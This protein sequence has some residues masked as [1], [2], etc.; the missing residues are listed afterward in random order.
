MSNML[1]MAFDHGSSHAHYDETSITMRAQVEVLA[2]QQRINEEAEKRS[3][4][5]HEFVIVQTDLLRANTAAFEQMADALGT[6]AQR[7]QPKPA[8]KKK[9]KAKR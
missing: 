7:Q 5:A 6:L 9:A 2:A 1:D 3:L 8:L 4:A